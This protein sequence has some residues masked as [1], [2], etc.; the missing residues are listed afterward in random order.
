MSAGQTGCGPMSDLHALAEDKHGP[1]HG[2]DVKHAVEQAQEMKIAI[3]GDP[4]IDSQR[5]LDEIAKLEN[6]IRDLF[7]ANSTAAGGDLK[8]EHLSKNV[9]QIIDPNPQQLTH[10]EI[11]AGGKAWGELENAPGMQPGETPGMSSDDGGSPIGEMPGATQ[12]MSMGGGGDMGGASSGIPG[13]GGAPSPGS[14]VQ[15]V[16]QVILD[17]LA[18]ALQPIPESMAL[19]A[20][21]Q[22]PPTIS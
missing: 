9:Q 20:P 12:G 15:G 3:T 6:Q 21:L 4:K 2:D 11:T 13:V 16:V 10:E 7:D 5:M 8:M 14:I 18:P 1:K 19:A 22:A 17:V